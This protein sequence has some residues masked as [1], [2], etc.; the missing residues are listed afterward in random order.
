M[1]VLIDGERYV[2]ESDNKNYSIGIGVTTHN[3]NKLVADTVARIKSFTPN[4]R[5]VVVDDASESPVNNIDAEVYR[6]KKNVGI[7]RAKNKCI[8]LLRDCTHIFLFDDDTYPIASEWYKPYVES[9]EPHLMYLFEDWSSGKPVGDDRIIYEDGS[10]VAHE[11][12]RGCMI[13]L[14]SSVLDVVGGFDTRYGKAMHEHLDLS[15][16]I[17]NAGLTTFRYMDVKDSDRLIHSM[18]EYQEVSTSIP[19][20]ERRLSPRRP[21]DLGDRRQVGPPGRGQRPQGPADPA[22]G[23]PHP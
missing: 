4:A 14:N 13:Y 20:P 22:R 12:A 6:F 8:E 11:H 17:Y 2:K 5:I 1:E 16:R 15:N 10:I 23:G 7:A 9:R 21:A 3:R 18:D 19:R